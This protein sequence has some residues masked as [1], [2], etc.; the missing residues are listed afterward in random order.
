M[1]VGDVSLLKYV[2][3]CDLCRRYSRNDSR[4]GRGIRD[5]INRTT[6]TSREGVSRMEIG[7]L[8]EGFKTDILSS[9]SSQLDALQVKKRKEEEDRA[10]AIFCP[11]CRK[12]H[13][14]K[15]WRLD[16]V[17]MCLLCNQEHPTKEFP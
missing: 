7:N 2:G 4:S 17:E 3:I 12:R 10:L 15:S 8:L 5:K 6:K 13:P 14:L 16:K 11:K 9:L 1:G